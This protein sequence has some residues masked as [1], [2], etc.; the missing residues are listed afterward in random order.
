M[1]QSPSDS[2]PAMSIVLGLITTLAALLTVAVGAT[3]FQLRASD[4]AGNGLAQAFL[5]G[6]MIALWLALAI[7]LVLT[8]ARQQRYQLPWTSINIS[9]LL[10]FAFAAAGQ[11]ACLAQLTGRNVDGWFRLVLQLAVVAPP[12]AILAHVVWR[13]FGAPLPMR[14][15]TLGVGIVVAFLSTVSVLGLLRP[16]PAPHEPGVD[17]LSFPALLLRGDSKIEVIAGPDDLAT[18]S[19][20]YVV[21]RPSDPLVVDSHFAIFELRDLKMGKGS[22]GMLVRGQGLEPVTF[23]LVPFEPSGTPES[24]RA[25]VLRVK[26]LSTDPDQDAAMRR[27]LAK[28]E[29]LDEMIAIVSRN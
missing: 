25:L 4:P 20:N 9:A 5:A 24:V 7:A 19:S 14:A 26:Y 11:V 3:V 8:T 1:T 6:S 13:A 15:A 12:V 18:M 23:R 22:L 10:L 17:T 28:A 29:T 2:A 16:K 27:D 21:N